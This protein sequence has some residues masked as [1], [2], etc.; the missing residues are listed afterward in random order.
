MKVLK[1]TATQY[2]QLNG[3]TNGV[4]TLEFIQ[5]NNNNW[6]VGTKVI[7]NG[8]FLE[9]RKELLDLEEISFNPKIEKK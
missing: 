7:E 8:N 9:I 1:A 4:S 3:Y 5:D 2:K 6:I